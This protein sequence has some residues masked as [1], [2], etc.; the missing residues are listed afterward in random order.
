MSASPATGVPLSDFREVIHVTEMRR[1]GK[2]DQIKGRI[3]STWGELS[4]DD[5]DQAR[6]DTEQLIGRIKEKTGESVDAIRKKLD[7]LLGEEKER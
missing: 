1:E 4:D 6:G 5:I 3:R 7:G 2:L